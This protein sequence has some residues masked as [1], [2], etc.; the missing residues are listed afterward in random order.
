MLLNPAA[1]A[2]EAGPVVRQ[3]ASVNKTG[4]VFK[5]KSLVQLAA[6]KIEQ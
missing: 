3:T 4:P 5:P 1:S 2:I 6:E